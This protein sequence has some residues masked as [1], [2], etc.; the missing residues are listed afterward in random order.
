MKNPQLTLDLMVKGMLPNL[1]LRTRQGV[2][3]P[4][5]LALKVLAKATRQEK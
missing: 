5:T 4:I 1:R 2:T 3:I